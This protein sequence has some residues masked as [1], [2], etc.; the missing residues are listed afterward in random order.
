MPDIGYLFQVDGYGESQVF[1]Q[2]FVVRA[3]RIMASG[4]AGRFSYFAQVNLITEPSL[5]DTRLRVALTDELGVEAGLVKTP[6]SAEFNTFRG[7]LP[8]SEPSRVVVALAPKRQIGA[9]LK[10][11]LGSTTIR[12][13]LYNGNGRV[14]QND[15]SGLM[16]VGR[17]EQRL[18][19]GDPENPSVLQVGINGAYSRDQDVFLPGFATSYAGSRLIGGMDAKFS[20]GPILASAEMNVA[21]FEPDSAGFDTDKLVPWGFALTTGYCFSSG[22]SITGRLDFLDR[23]LQASGD[24]LLVGGYAFSPVPGARFSAEYRFNLT[25]SRTSQVLIRFQLARKN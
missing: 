18:L 5:L 25:D 6:F 10:A 9:T 4:K 17:L 23:D 20:S 16:G 21:E 3:S 19:I 15:G 2:G 22:H 14:L 11:V 24:Y 7:H 13:G 8:L 1:E 12:G